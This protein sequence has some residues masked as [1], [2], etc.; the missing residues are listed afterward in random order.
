MILTGSSGGKVVTF[1]ITLP[2]FDP[3]ELLLLLDVFELPEELLLLL[4]LE[5]PEELLLLLLLELP[6][7]LLLLELPV[8][9]DPPLSL[10]PPTLPR[11]NSASI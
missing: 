4:L 3:D 11:E 5:L 9:V 8:D 2:V 6:D 7:E 1:E 10:I